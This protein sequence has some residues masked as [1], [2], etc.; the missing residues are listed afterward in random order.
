MHPDAERLF[1]LD[2]ALRAEADEVLAESGI[3]AILEQA[4]YEAVGSYVMRTMTWR[5]LDFERCEEPDWERHWGVGTRLGSTGWCF[6]LSCV[7]ADRYTED[8]HGL[9]WGLRVTDPAL[10]ERT[11]PG[12]PRVW[13]LDLWTG[14]AEVLAPVAPK[15]EAWAEAMT[16]E[17]RSHVLAIK[18]AVCGEAEYRHGLLSVHIYEAVLEEGVRGVEEFREWWRRGYVEGRAS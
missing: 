5:D 2:A 6:R 18:E 4:G 3:G 11:P 13:K 7:D 15:R 10:G 9:Y 12:D 17:A 8:E 14:S 16:E 1:A